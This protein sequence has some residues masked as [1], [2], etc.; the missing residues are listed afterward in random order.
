[1]WESI[2]D[3]QYSHPDFVAN[4]I[5]PLGNREIINHPVSSIISFWPG[6]STNVRLLYIP[7]VQ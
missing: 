1:M 5:V 2:V 4:T 6:C 7:V 3:T